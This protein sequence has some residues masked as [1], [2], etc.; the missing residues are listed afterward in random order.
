MAVRIL[1]IHRRKDAETSGELRCRDHSP[2][3]R[4]ERSMQ[5]GAAC[6]LKATLQY[7]LQYGII[8]KVRRLNNGRHWDNI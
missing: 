8:R 1:K 7:R 5:D 2:P 6:T 3:P 4:Q